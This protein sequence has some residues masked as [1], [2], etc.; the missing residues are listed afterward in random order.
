MNKKITHTIHRE[1][2]FTILELIVALGIIAIIMGLV[3]PNAMKEMGKSKTKSAR[4]QIEQLAGALDMYKLDVGRYPS[5]AQ[6][7]QALLEQPNDEKRWNGSYIKKNNVPKDP[8]GQEYHYVSPGEHGKFD[9]YSL[10]EDKEKGG[11]G[12]D[13]DVTSWE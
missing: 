5:T 1:S 12:T 8:W 4:I 7:L 13:Q 6:G 11:E 9:L 2:G 10:G 3:A